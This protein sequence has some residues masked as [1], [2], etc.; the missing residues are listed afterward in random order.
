MRAPRSTGSW[1]EQFAD[2]LGAIVGQLGGTSVSHSKPSKLDYSKP[3]RSPLVANFI[4]SMPRIRVS[5]IRRIRGVAANPGA[6]HRV[7]GAARTEM[8]VST[9]VPIGLHAVHALGKLHVM[10]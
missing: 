1:L 9:S 2:T 8:N 4:H 10:T 3:G 7:A 6:L 5:G